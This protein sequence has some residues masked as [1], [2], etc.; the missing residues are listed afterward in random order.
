VKFIVE[1][2]KSWDVKVHPNKSVKNSG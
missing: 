1:N 2:L